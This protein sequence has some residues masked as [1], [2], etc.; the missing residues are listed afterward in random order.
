MFLNNLF[1]C[2]AKGHYIPKRPAN[3]L[4]YA[5]DLKIACGRAAYAAVRYK[6][7]SH[8]RSK[9]R[10]SLSRIALASSDHS[11]ATAVVPTAVSGVFTVRRNNISCLPSCGQ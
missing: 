10:I 7:I 9:V 6:I 4:E 5:Q 8:G 2:S 11:A 3:S 1:S